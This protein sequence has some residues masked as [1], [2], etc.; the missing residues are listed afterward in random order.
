M[1]SYAQH[2]V[3]FIGGPYDGYQHDLGEMNE[4]IAERAALPVSENIIRAVT[5]DEHGPLYPYKRVAL[6]QLCQS[7]SAWRY[8][9]LGE[10][11]SGPSR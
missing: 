5:G 7:E 9:F 3:E 1:S 4:E 2:S 8:V 11:R 6:Y 10:M